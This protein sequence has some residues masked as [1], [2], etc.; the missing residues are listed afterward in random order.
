LLNLQEHVRF[1]HCVRGA[2]TKWRLPRKRR[3]LS[4]LELLVVMAI[5]AIMMSMLLVV[6][7]KVWRTVS[8]WRH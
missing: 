2:A 7:G 6:L 8:V 4:L 5:I 1:I 3:G